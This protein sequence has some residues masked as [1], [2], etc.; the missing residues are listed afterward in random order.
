ML[1]CEFDGSDAL[2][3]APHPLGTRHC[4]IN[5]VKARS[6]TVCNE[7]LISF[8][9]D[10]TK[11]QYTSA[12]APRRIHRTKVTKPTLHLLALAIADIWVRSKRPS[13]PP[14]RNPFVQTQDEL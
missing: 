6:S 5:R 1:Y 14:A 12:N 2:S 10:A 7:V 11:S 8:E 9:R 13:R 3:W 4:N